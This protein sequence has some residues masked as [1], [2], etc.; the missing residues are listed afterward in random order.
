MLTS[1][2]DPLMAVTHPHPYDYYAD[3]VRST[4]CYHDEQLGCWIATS[5]AAVTAVLTNDRC[6]VRP[7]KEPVP[8]ALLGTPAATIFGNLVR[9]NDG[10]AHDQAQH[11]VAHTLASI[12]TDALA[13]PSRAWARQLA[14]E[15]A[16]RSDRRQITDFA[17]AIS[18]Y[19]IAS[20]LGIPRDQ[21]PQVATWMGEFVRCLAPG[22][23]A[24][25]L[26]VAS[27]AAGHL[28]ELLRAIVT[29]GDDTS[30]LTR[31]NREA[32]Q[33]GLQDADIV[34]AN[35]IGFMSQAYEA[36]AG[37]I[38]NTLLV[39]ATHPEI[40]ERVIAE[41]SLLR[42][43]I[44]ETL[45]YDP[46]VHNTRRFLAQDGIVAGQPMHTGDAIL[47]VLAAANRDPAANA[48]PELFDP[49][50]TERQSFTFGLGAHA[51]VGTL[52]ATTIAAAGVAE[53]LPAEWLTASLATTVTYRAS[54]NTRVPLWAT[55]ENTP[56]EERAR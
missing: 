54:S 27:E 35:G 42:Q 1:P 11:A 53:L 47:V 7:P 29:E 32:Q 4:P 50:R 33:A 20:L 9:M 12:Q 30:L 38:G 24:E 41:P 25:Q 28:L 15:H 6:R 34:I 5:A 13:A 18:V 46:P 48:Q 52:I 16:A 56:H 14:H 43:V 31:L 8:P 36:T 26:T 44:A 23:S 22:S 37:L 39:C 17:F 10:Q 49:W 55:R 51:C 45:R 3:L 40:R 2:H 19:V 21:L